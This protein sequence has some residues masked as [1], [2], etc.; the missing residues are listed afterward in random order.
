MQFFGRLMGY[1]LTL[2]TLPYT[3]TPDNVNNNNN[4]KETISEDIRVVASGE[5]A[6]ENSVPSKTT[7][8]E[9]NLDDGEV[10]NMYNKGESL[11]MAG[12][13]EQA[14]NPVVE[15]EQSFNMETSGVR[16]AVS[17]DSTSASGA[18]ASTNSME[19][20]PSVQATKPTG[21][22]GEMSQV[23]QEDPDE[24][25]L[26]TA[27]A[28][29]TSAIVEPSVTSDQPPLSSSATSPEG[30]S[31][32]E[33][34]IQARLSRSRNRSS[35]RLASPG[36]VGGRKSGIGAVPDVGESA[37]NGLN[38]SMTQEQKD[39]TLKAR[40]RSTAPVRPGA[41]NQPVPGA[42]PSPIAQQALSASMTQEQKDQALKA[43]LRRTAPV[44]GH[45]AHGAHPS[46]PV[47]EPPQVVQSAP[48]TQDQKDQALKA[49]LRR[50]APVAAGA[51]YTQPSPPA[52]AP[53]EPTQSAPM[54]QEQKDQ[55]LKA[56]LRRTAPAAVGA[57][58]Q[59][60]P[61]QPTPSVPMTQE[62]RDQELKARL[63]NTAPATPTQPSSMT[64]ES[65]PMTQEQKDQALKARLR[66]GARGPPPQPQTGTPASMS[67]ADQDMLAKSNARAGRPTRRQQQ[68]HTQAEQDAEAKARARAGYP[69]EGPPVVEGAQQLSPPVVS[70]SVS[71]AAGS[72]QGL[73]E[74]ERRREQRAAARAERRGNRDE[75]APA[76]ESA[77]PQHQPVFS[78][79]NEDERQRRYDAKMSQMGQSNTNMRGQGRVTPDVV[80]PAAPQSQTRQTTST[81]FSNMSEAERQ[82]RYEAKMN[83]IDQDHVDRREKLG[84]DENIDPAQEQP[85]NGTSIYITSTP[86]SE[87][88]QASSSE[89]YASRQ[90]GV[91]TTADRG[92]AVA[93]EVE[94]GEYTQPMIPDDELAVAIAIDPDEEEDEEKFY[95][96]AVEYDPDSK[97]PIYKNR[98][99][100]LYGIGGACVLI[101]LIVVLVLGLSS[102]EEVPDPVV[103]TFAPS[104]APSSP[105]TTAEIGI[106][107]SFLAQAVSPEIAFQGTA[108]RRAM[109]WIMNEDPMM[110]RPNDPRLVQRYMMAFLYFHST[111]NGESEWRSCN[112]P[113]EGE[114]DF[115]VFE[116]F[117]RDPD[118]YND[119]IVYTPKPDRIRWLSGQDV[120]K[121]E[122]VIC[123]GGSE[124]QGVSLCKFRCL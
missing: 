98:R 101:I 102:E 100:R 51:A 21:I 106:Y 48:M 92:V 10:L 91:V 72:D 16:A 119:T 121:W 1:L 39:Q 107:T 14:G 71:S 122:G 110:L 31:N 26:E 64:T 120:C 113:K 37:T 97:P 117:G 74:L 60:S 44:T 70:G 81:P 103:I 41:S 86:K 96:H 66:S 7:D 18:F 89:P 40:I 82:R 15:R 123:A 76:P 112:P 65:V 46:Q 5:V 50:T 108:L 58:Y 19:A 49:R 59:P 83:Q 118:P 55:A 56:R 6:E 23:S 25:H 57:G 80:E 95:A 52:P 61:S 88:V 111:N 34:R 77:P 93:P 13:G 27:E 11:S 17:K 99:F 116:E 24:V 3:A 29:P 9:E 62:Q 73:T 68:R 67:Q 78:N 38:S 2:S 30:Q 36:I 32:M 84:V 105:P 8:E 69:A 53:P 33:A 28:P 94:F 4:H 104:S 12:N 43:R 47:M 63:R 79:M 54:T 45:A 124:V 75:P 85:R 109:D 35:E 87:E 22:P 115:C 114:D 20:T 42:Q 90:P